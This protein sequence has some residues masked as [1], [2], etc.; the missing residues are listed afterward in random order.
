M[1]PLVK[2]EIRLLLPGWLAI[3]VLEVLTPW[4][5]TDLD[6]AF[7][8]LW[9]VFFFGMTILA[10]DSFGREFSPGI[11]T[12]LMSQPV[13]RR[14]IWRTKIAVLLLAS[15]L[16]FAAYFACCGLRLHLAVT[17]ITSVWHANPKLIRGDFRDSMIF[18]AVVML[19]ALTG[20]LW[21]SL[22]LRQSAAAFWITLLAPVGLL[23]LFALVWTALGIPKVFHPGSALF[24][25]SAAGVYSVASYWLAHRLFH[26]A[27]DAAWTGDIIDFSKWRYF[28]SGARSTDSV[29]RRRP[30]AALL[31]KE[32]QLHSV[33]LI[34]AGALLA[35][36]IAVIAMRRV[37]GHFEPNSMAGTISEFYWS[38]WLVMPLVIG[39]TAVA[40]EQRLG[41]ME[42]QFC[43]PASRRFQ[44]ILKFLP[45]ISFSLLF[46][47]LMPY[48]LEGLASTVGAP[49]PDFRS[50]GHDVGSNPPI[51]VAS[52]ALGLFLAS[53]FGS[54]LTKNVLQAMGIAIATICGCCLFTYLAGNLHSFLGVTWNPPLTIGI[55]VLTA[56]VVFPTLTY[57]NFKYFQEHGRMWRR[58]VWGFTG[59]IL[60][61]FIS[62][63]VLFNRVWEVFEPAEP[64][65]GPAIFS[66]KNPPAF[67]NAPRD[68]LLLRL[69]D[70]RVW[71]DS[72]D[73]HGI[74][75][76]ENRLVMLLREVLNPL[77]TS[78][79]PS[80]FL[81]GSNWVSVVAGHLYTVVREGSQNY[82]P[83]MGFL[84]SVGIQP[85]GT[86]WASG[87]SDQLTWTAEK[88]T[89]FGNETNWQQIARAFS[90]AS[91]LLL[92]KDGTLW[93]WGTN[94]FDLD[95]WPQKWPGLRAFQPHQ[96]GTNSD[97]REI[98]SQNGYLAKNVAGNVWRIQPNS[99]NGRI[100][101]MRETNFDQIPFKQISQAFGNNPVTYTRKNG[102]LEVFLRRYINVPG[103]GEQIK[104]ETLQSNRETNWL[105]GVATWNWMVALK[106]DGTL[107]KWDPRPDFNHP[108]DY[109]APPTRLGIHNDWIAIASVD[110]GV[111]TLAADG[112]LWLWPNRGNYDGRTLLKLPK[113]PQYLGNIFGKA[114]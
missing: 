87:K 71:F 68:N 80:Q 26:R 1:N 90:P 48:L 81:S 66:L 97:W 39:G 103:Q 93:L 8:F 7:N 53:V 11:F 62:S 54:T 37:H 102:T 96:I 57:R 60:F 44:F 46:G 113:Q 2:K 19:V 111:V 12:L 89:Q 108:V 99:E 52:I 73:W 16:I 56:L 61:I 75:T 24:Y 34:C 6:S 101:L 18:S 3:L 13:E 55:A 104:F 92:K 91:V 112:S 114:D 82:T 79:G 69:P 15:V 78:A 76:P 51:I 49:N 5:L 85:D 22:L 106:S 41:V 45:A 30:L 86:L 64:A 72:V 67:L 29:R 50:S 74:V 94:H 33:S 58:N 20:G 4:L 25:S 107:W 88:L 31:K 9:V 40:E 43:L 65:H 109:T 27:Q 36:H 10:V 63:A 100:E 84:D 14:R 28:E 47:A 98:A 21:T 70:G 42:E 110:N 83:I 59:A 105:S 95:D 32:F 23:F 77:P 17:D 38:L 35:V